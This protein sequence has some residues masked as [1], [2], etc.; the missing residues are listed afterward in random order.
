MSNRGSA[1]RYARALLDVGVAEGGV[2]QIDQELMG[3]AGMFKS[4]PELESAL[5]NPAVP[6]SAKRAVVDDLGSRLKL[7]PPLRKLLLMLADRDRMALV[8]ELAEVYRERLME[9]QQ[10][11]RAEVTS[12]VPLTPDRAAQ[13]E[14][15][16]AEATGRRVTMTTR[17]DPALIGGAVARIGTIVYDGS[18]ATQLEKLRERLTQER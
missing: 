16:L 4:S 6:V 14:R 2:E 13:F 8:P 5:T 15:R 9:H 3:F 18:V 1:A 12:A 11:I 10:V 7:S 17:V